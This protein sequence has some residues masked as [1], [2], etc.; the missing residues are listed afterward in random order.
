MTRMSTRIILAFALAATLCSRVAGQDADRPNVVFIL[1]DDLGAHD[2]SNEG[3]AYYES[4]RIDGIARAGMKF[5]R[6]YAASRVCSPSRASIMTGKTPPSHG[7]TTWIGDDSGEAWSRR[8]LHDSHMPPDYARALRPDEITIAEAFRDA[9]Y[10][11]FFAGKWHLGGEGSWPTDHGFDINKGGWDSGGPRGGYFAPWQNPNLEPGPDGESL[12]IRLARE[13]EAFID[14]NKDG[15]FFAFLS[16]YAV[17]GPIQTT[18]DLWRKY[19]DKAV[20]MGPPDDRF[21]FDRRL[22]VRTVQDCPIYAG[23]IETMDDAVGIVLDALDRHGLADNTI[24]C[25]TSD[26][27]GVSSGD[28]FSTSNLP[29]RGGKGRQWEGGI[30]V[31]AYVR[32]P[33]I[34]EGLVTRTPITGPDWYP[35]L[36][37]LA[38]IELPDRQLVE[39]LSLA[40]VLRHGG[41]GAQ[42]PLY[43]HYPH[44]CNQ[45]GEPSSMVIDGDDKLIL[46]HE[47]NRLE[48]YDIRADPG[49]RVDLL[50]SRPARALE[51]EVMLTGWLDS[52][53]AAMPVPDPGF[54]AS[55]REQRWQRLAGPFQ[56]NLEARHAEYLS[57]LYRPNKTWWQ[58]KPTK[59]DAP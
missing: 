6:A 59:H 33:G 50:A 39:G 24:V 49:E 3:S 27:G 36:L 46:Y 25:F 58:S 29:L 16:F 22:P 38:G 21:V 34:M 55:K 17:H 13:T 4:P 52:V 14:Q 48:M 47:D 41:R 9:G 28:A 12:T 56:N 32:G 30:R 54:E 1:A 15:P 8:G 23:M 2:L 57:D 45:G 19:R 18:E 37:D 40:P 26:N 44:Y 7:V 51:L 11:T 43:F 10:R 5:E 35:T 20:A 53:N 42:R 31:P